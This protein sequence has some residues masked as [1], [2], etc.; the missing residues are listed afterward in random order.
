MER[1][2]ATMASVNEQRELANEIAETIATSAYG[3]EFDDVG[4][5]PYSLESSQV[6]NV[7]EGVAQ[8]GIGGVR[9]GPAERAV[10]WSGPRSYTSAG[11]SES[12]R[13]V[14]YTSALFQ[15]SG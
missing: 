15:P 14:L 11:W 7:Y 3:P 9:A 2:D 12:G 5:V 8:G 1:V 4:L 13:C 6:L 10:E